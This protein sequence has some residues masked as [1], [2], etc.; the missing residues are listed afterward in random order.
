MPW[1]CSRPDA[2]WEQAAACLHACALRVGCVAGA[3]HLCAA[4]A[5]AVCLQAPDRRL[6]GSPALPGIAVQALA[7][8]GSR[9]MGLEVST[10]VRT[11]QP[12][13]C[14]MTRSACTYAGV[15]AC[16]RACE[17]VLVCAH[18]CSLPDDT[19]RTHLRLYA[20]AHSRART[21]THTCMQARKRVRTLAH[22]CMCLRR[23]DRATSPAA[24]GS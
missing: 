4:P 13:P 21:H 24:S 14:R 20:C 16:A 3:P 19:Q 23:W 17:P 18:V 5:H 8:A 6:V 15:C 1:S 7:R 9:V 12:P 10:H 22:M 11:C 2:G